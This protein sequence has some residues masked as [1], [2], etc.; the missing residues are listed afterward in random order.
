MNETETF[1]E[2]PSDLRNVKTRI[3]RMKGQIRGVE[4]RIEAFMNTVCDFLKK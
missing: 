1:K 2:S 3:A 4:P